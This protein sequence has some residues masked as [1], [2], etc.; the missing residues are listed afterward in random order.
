[1]EFNE[2]E[3][4]RI[5]VV[6]DEP[7]MLRSINI[8]LGADY[9]LFLVNSGEAAIDFL[10]KQK[11]DLI[12]LDYKMPTMSGSEVL[13]NLQ[14]NKNTKRIPVIFL[15]GKNDRK[16]VMSVVQL[17]PDGYILKSLTPQE[18]KDSVANFFETRVVNF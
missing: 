6:D 17:K 12:L 2:R 16:T 10:Y 11:V 15:T 14:S 1:M 13:T 4:K 8:W 7:I 18:I 3:R 9:D 5:L